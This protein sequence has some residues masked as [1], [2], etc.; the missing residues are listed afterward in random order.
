[1]LAAQGGVGLWHRLLDKTDSYPETSA[2]A[3][4]TFA[5]A[6]E[7]ERVDVGRDC[8]SETVGRPVI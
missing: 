6:R 3:I 8:K 5:V 1:V 2:F 4:F 7:P